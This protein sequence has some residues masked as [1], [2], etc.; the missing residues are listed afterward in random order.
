MLEIHYR[1]SN[2]ATV[3]ELG[4]FPIY[5]P[6]CESISKLYLHVKGKEPDSLLQ[7][8]LQTSKQLHKNGIKSWYSGMDTILNE[9]KLD[10]GNKSS[11]KLHLNSFRRGSRKFSQGG[12]GVQIPKRGLTENFKMAKTNNL[13]IPGGGVRT[14]CPPP[15][16]PS[17]SAHEF[18]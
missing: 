7:Q 4:R 17:G 5:N 12:G 14:P 1:V 3:G 6:I 9:L 15:P 16:P 18:V 8:T 10:E 11:V 2:L 13:A